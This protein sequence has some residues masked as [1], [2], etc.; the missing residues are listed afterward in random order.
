MDVLPPGLIYIPN[1]LDQVYID[2]LLYH[3]NISNEWEAV[4]EGKN[5]RKVVQYGYKYNYTAG[6][7]DSRG[8]LNQQSE[9]AKPFPE[10]IKTLRD[11]MID[12]ITEDSGPPTGETFNQCIINKY[13][14][15][16]GIGPHIDSLAYG[17]VIGCFT[18]VT[19]IG[20]S[21]GIVELLHPTNSKTKYPIITMPGSLYVM[22]GDS[23]YKWKHQMVAR[24]TDDRRKRATRISVTFRS[25]L[26][27]EEITRRDQLLKK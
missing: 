17:A 5:S 24:K 20:D 23:R 3:L 1:A 4:G 22:T 26:S 27:Q 8:N 25:L 7:N 12:H 18:I 9:A 16:Q 21:P 6:G 15:G 19:G 14:P 13:E 10:I 2:E 11:I